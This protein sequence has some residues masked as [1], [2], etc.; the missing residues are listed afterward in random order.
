[1]EAVAY[2]WI[3]ISTAASRLGVSGQTIRNRIKEGLY[4][5]LNFKRGGMNGTLIKVP[6][7]NDLKDEEKQGNAKL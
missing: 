5:T 4:E 1:M 3:S 6:I 2:E 7:W